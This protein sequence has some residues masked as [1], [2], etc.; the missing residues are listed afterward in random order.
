MNLKNVKYILALVGVSLLALVAVQLYWANNAYKLN[1]KQ[2]NHKV[3]EAISKT[4]AEANDHMACF[5]LFSKVH[6]RPNEGF[7]MLRQGWKDDTFI[8][9]GEKQPDTVTMYSTFKA[10]GF[11]YDY[12]NL[13][14]S[15]PVT[16]DLVLRFRF[17][18][19]DTAQFNQ[20]S[21]LQYEQISA[22]NFRDIISGNRP[23]YEQY[24]TIFL[25]SM[26][27]KYFREESITSKFHYAIIRSDNDSV[28]Y[29]T[30]GATAADLLASP[31]QASLAT[32]KYFTKPYRL[33]VVLADK[34]QLV[35]ATL[36]STLLCSAVVIL[37]LFFAFWYFM[38]IILR[39]KKLQEMKNDFI[40]NMTHE[41]NTPIANIALSVETMVESSENMPD[42]TKKILN[43]IG[44]ENER[45]K[46][47]VERVLQI[48]AI[49]KESFEL[50][51]ETIE[52]DTLVRQVIS[53]FEIKVA[54]YGG[55]IVFN[56][57]SQNTHVFA[58]ETHLINVLYNLVDNALK[59]GGP[60]PEVRITLSDGID[61]FRIAVE[62]DGIGMSREEQK[63]IFNKFYRAHTGNIHNV[64]GFG[65]G[66]S[67]VKSIVAAHKGTVSVTSQP[68]KGS[69]FE[70]NLPFD[71]S[72]VAA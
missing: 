54:N 28:A 37:V 66:L 62:D 53:N 44:T 27:A 56:N 4:A 24:D 71:F 41:F 5:E 26:L 25:D 18:M 42:R 19:D 8:P 35:L 70:I 16:A 40:D 57:T 31:L 14:F 55:R 63:K 38:R 49:E 36:W 34:Q 46:E 20:E 9:A 30:A 45:L 39:Q 15:R 47:N 21:K 10:E 43:I 33:A 2:L 68:G 29:M 23:V 48:A 60:Q 12:N 1:E 7:Y 65:L 61:G 17:R 69:C 22:A 50:E 52:I 58:D 72:K 11:R 3:T 67:Y 32:D 13:M 51:P 6:I 59:Y 64:K